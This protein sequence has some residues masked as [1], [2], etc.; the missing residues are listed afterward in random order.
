MLLSDRNENER[1]GWWQRATARSNKQKDDSDS[2]LRVNETIS[3]TML[4]IF[5]GFRYCLLFQVNTTAF[6][7]LG[8]KVHKWRFV[9]PMCYTSWL[10]HKHCIAVHHVLGTPLSYHPA[11]VVWVKQSRQNWLR[12]VQIMYKTVYFKQSIQTFNFEVHINPTAQYK[13]IH[14]QPTDKK[15]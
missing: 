15:L 12:T 1:R 11:A 10:K 2:I 9:W 13:V 8:Y 6:W 4:K 7:P 3:S 14:S 5:L